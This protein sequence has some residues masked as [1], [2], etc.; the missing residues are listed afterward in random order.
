M[1]SEQQRLLLFHKLQFL[2]QKG[3]HCRYAISC[4]S[5]IVNPNRQQ[6][7]RTESGFSATAGRCTIF[8]YPW[9]RAK[10]EASRRAAV[11]NCWSPTRDAFSRSF[12]QRAA[13][14]LRRILRWCLV[15]DSPI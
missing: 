14:A 15:P 7:L 10:D 8:P 2:E 13:L 12:E 4:W 6:S 1:I 9:P 5:P 11:T 3:V